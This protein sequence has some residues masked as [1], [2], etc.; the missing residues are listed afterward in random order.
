[1]R[2]SNSRIEL[3]ANTGHLMNIM[4]DGIW[5][6]Y[7]LVNKPNLCGNDIFARDLVIYYKRTADS[8]IKVCN[9]MVYKVKCIL[10]FIQL[11]ALV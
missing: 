7:A 1:M 6:Q 3:K 5:K 4:R 10:D 8:I 9:P 11:T 2:A